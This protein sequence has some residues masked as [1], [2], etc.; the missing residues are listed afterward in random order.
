MILVAAEGSHELAHLLAVG[1]TKVGWAFDYKRREREFNLAALP[2]LGGLQYKTAFIHLWDTARAAYRMKQAM[3]KNF[4]TRR[5]A[6]N[7]EV[8]VDIEEGMLLTGWSQYLLS[9]KPR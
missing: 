8:L 5:H 6:S 7:H 9:V 2:Q 3:L 4:D 1:A